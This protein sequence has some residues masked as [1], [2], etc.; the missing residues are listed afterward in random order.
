MA[1]SPRRN[2]LF[3]SGELMNLVK[4]DPPGSWC[5]YD[6]APFTDNATLLVEL[7]KV[8]R[9]SASSRQPLP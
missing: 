2:L 5:H 7:V 9:D 3:K 6:A 1:A 8:K 4:I